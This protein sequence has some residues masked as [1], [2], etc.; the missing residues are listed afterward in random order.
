[1]PNTQ[2]V[3]NNDLV[4]SEVAVEGAVPAPQKPSMLESLLPFI[5]IM[6]VFYFMIIRPQSKKLKEHQQQVAAVKKGDEVVTSGG[7]LGVVTKVEEGLFH[8]EIADSVIVKVKKDTISE[9][10]RLDGKAESKAESKPESKSKAT[11]KSAKKL[12]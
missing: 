10:V 1:M 5:L 8:V 3:E 9:V 2:V 7:I 4:A 6:V 12:K 11:S